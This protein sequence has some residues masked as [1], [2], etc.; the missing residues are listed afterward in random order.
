MAQC[1]QLTP[2]PFKGSNDG[3]LSSTWPAGVGPC[4]PLIMNRCGVMERD[5]DVSRKLGC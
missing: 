3:A 5:N 4:E 1:N 2:L